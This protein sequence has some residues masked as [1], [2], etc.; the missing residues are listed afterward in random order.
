MP[1][2]GASR[3]WRPSA[4]RR[5]AGVRAIRSS[6]P[7]IVGDGLDVDAY[8]AR[9]VGEGD[10]DMVLVREREMDPA[11]ERTFGPGAAVVVVADGDL[12]REDGPGSRL[13][14]QLTDRILG[15]DPAQ[16]P[17][18]AGA[19]CA[20]FIAGAF[21]RAQVAAHDQLLR[22]R[23]RPAAPGQAPAARP[24]FADAAHLRGELHG[25]HPL[26][27]SEPPVR[28]ALQPRPDAAVGTLQF[29]IAA[30]RAGPYRTDPGGG[31]QQRARAGRGPVEPYA[32]QGRGEDQ[33][34]A[35]EFQLHP[36]AEELAR[37]VQ[38]GA[39]RGQGA[40]RSADAVGGERADLVD[41]GERRAVEHPPVPVEG[42]GADGRGP[43]GGEGRGVGGRRSRVAGREM[44]GDGGVVAEAHPYPAVLGRGGGDGQVDGRGDGQPAQGPYVGVAGDEVSG[45][46]LP[47]RLGGQFQQRGHGDDGEAVGGLG[48]VV[49]LEVDAVV[50]DVREGAEGEVAGGAVGGGDGGGEWLG[51]VEGAGGRGGAVGAEGAGGRGRLGGA[52]GAGSRGRLGDAT[53]AGARGRL[54]GGDEAGDGGLPAAAAATV[55]VAARVSAR[56]ASRACRTGSAT[57]G[58][59]CGSAPPPPPPPPPSGEGAGGGFGGGGGP[60]GREKPGARRRAAEAD[61]R[62]AEVE[63]HRHTGS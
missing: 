6:A 8:G 62:R 30:H 19:R 34:V 40:Q 42:L 47:G 60:G 55:R 22:G 49:G 21:G 61:Q 27:R 5:S 4:R 50:A 37:G 51:Y 12:G 44:D 28:P 56:R 9:P 45:P 38:E 31:R 59:G 46:R 20:L 16:Q 33:P 54:G 48:P 11:G 17:C 57:G 63:P 10:G 36:V 52:E 35:G 41:P 23:V 43:A 39:G 2:P 32:V 3:A 15:G 18:R 1:G 14:Q 25:P 58:Q 53:G 7:R 26:V 24:G 13:P 29:H